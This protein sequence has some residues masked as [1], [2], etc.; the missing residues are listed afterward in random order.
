MDVIIGAQARQRVEIETITWQ[1]PT[2]LVIER[3]DRRPA[4]GVNVEQMSVGVNA[5]L[6]RDSDPLPAEMFWQ[7]GGHA[8]LELGRGLLRIHLHN[9]TEQDVALKIRIGPA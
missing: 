8:G 6:S 7:D 3:S 4:V 1:G 2:R 9:T 5:V